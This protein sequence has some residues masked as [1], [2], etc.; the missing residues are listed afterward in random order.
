MKNAQTV[1]M[2]PI[3]QSGMC[4]AIVSCGG[5]VLNLPGRQEGGAREQHRMAVTVAKAW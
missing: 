4:R 5:G 2:A 3:K 1:I